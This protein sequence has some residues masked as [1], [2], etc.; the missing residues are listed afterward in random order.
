MKDGYTGGD[1]DLNQTG[2]RHVMGFNNID[3]ESQQM[4][5]KTEKY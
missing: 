1:L 3:N 4:M 5:T 2:L